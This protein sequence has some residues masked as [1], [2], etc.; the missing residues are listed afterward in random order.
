MAVPIGSSWTD[1]ADWS[2]LN[3]A[4]SGELQSKLQPAQRRPD[5]SAGWDDRQ[6]SLSVLDHG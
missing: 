4:H 6:R 2:F 1:A 5:R 3:R